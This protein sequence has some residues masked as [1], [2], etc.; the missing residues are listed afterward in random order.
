MVFETIALEI[1]GDWATLTLSRPQARNAMSDELVDEMHLALDQLAQASDVRGVTFRGAGDIF[2]AGG[3]LKGFQKNFQAERTPEQVKQSSV[4]IGEMFYKIRTLPQVTVF[5][6]HG[7]AVAGGLGMACAGD[8]VIAVS[9][10]KMGLSE[11]SI[12]IVPAQIAPYVVERVGAFKARYIMLTSSRFT[13]DEGAGF[14]LVDFLEADMIAAE[15]RLAEIKKQVRNCA[16]NA[17]AGTKLLLEETKKRS[18]EDM[19]DYAAQAFV[20][21]V[22][23][24]EGK[25]GVASFLEKRK[26]NWAT[27]NE[28]KD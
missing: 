2:C 7:A 15:A 17:N 11:T 13:A 22:R 18:L 12:G 16:P 4:I 6:L 25:E 27:K 20:D 19:I 8:M 3:D 9:G 26:P 10:T 23:G 21:S 14:G 5:L 1:E 24:D 28:P